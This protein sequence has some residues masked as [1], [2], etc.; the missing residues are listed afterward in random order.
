M[1]AEA[2]NS[3]IKCD[4]S[5]CEW[6]LS[7]EFDSIPQ[8]HKKTCPKCRKGEIISD[9]DLMVWYAAKS[10]LIASDIFV[11]EGKM[12]R[13]DILIDTAEMRKTRSHSKK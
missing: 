11:P 6:E 10:M 2:K 8:W 7:C 12:P 9:A 4:E 1:K 5:G 3:V 13:V